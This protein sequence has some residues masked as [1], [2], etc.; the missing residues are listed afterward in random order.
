MQR[1][2]AGYGSTPVHTAAETV[3]AAMLD[4]MVPQQQRSAGTCPALVHNL[5]QLPGAVICLPKLLSGLPETVGRAYRQLD[6]PLIVGAQVI[7]EGDQ[8]DGHA[9]LG[10][11][12]K[13]VLHRRLEAG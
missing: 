10:Q 5:N 11:L 2:C 8:V 3:S 9:S 7:I 1:L 6:D 4:R 13:G 12:C